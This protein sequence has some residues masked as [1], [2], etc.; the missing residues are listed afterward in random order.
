MDAAVF[1]VLTFTNNLDD[2][3]QWSIN[4]AISAKAN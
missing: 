3:P 1:L 4:I 2:V